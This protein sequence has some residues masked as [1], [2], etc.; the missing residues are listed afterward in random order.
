MKPRSGVYDAMSAG[1]F[2]KIKKEFFTAFFEALE[3]NEGLE[4]MVFTAYIVGI[5]L[6]FH[7]YK[8]LLLTRSCLDLI[9]HFRPSS[10]GSIASFVPWPLCPCNYNHYS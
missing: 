4:E 1:R 8:L 10:V 5:K 9:R 3:S 6:C 7:H 2:L